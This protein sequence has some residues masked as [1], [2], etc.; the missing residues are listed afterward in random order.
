M[1]GSNAYF[2]SGDM[3]TL[4]TG[5]YVELKMLPLSFAEYC[6]GLEL[7]TPGSLMTKPEKYAAYLSE[8]SF[9]YTL[10]LHG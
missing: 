6:E 2:M 7:Y 4:L 5:R 10:Q 3:A 8:S 1:T 9:P